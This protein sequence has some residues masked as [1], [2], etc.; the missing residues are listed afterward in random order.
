MP[1]P[2]LLIEHVLGGWWEERNDTLRQYCRDAS[3]GRCRASIEQMVPVNETR[4][5]VAA[6]LFPDM[7][8]CCPVSPLCA[9]IPLR[10][11]EIIVRRQDWLM[12][13][14]KTWQ[15]RRRDGLK[16]KHT[17]WHAIKCILS[18]CSQGGGRGWLLT[19][20]TNENNKI[21]QEHRGDL[22]TCTVDT[23]ALCTC[24]Y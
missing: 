3:R 23:Y 6:L 5:E 9:C 15:L 18:S 13:K 24:T 12:E 17:S 16:K 2:Y 7:G 11:R 10:L 22:G 1:A 20:Q 14:D 8:N 21:T 4:A 19:I